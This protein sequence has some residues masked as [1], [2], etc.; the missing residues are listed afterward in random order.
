MKKFF[1]SIIVAM[2]ALFTT[3]CVHASTLEVNAKRTIEIKGVIRGN[4]IQAANV[5][6]RMSAKSDDDVFLIINSPGGAIYP[7]IQ[8]VSAMRM[9]QARGVTIKCLVPV[10][11]ASMAYQF[12]LYCDER[13]ALRNSLLLWHPAH[14]QIAGNADQLLYASKRLR[15]IEKPLVRDLIQIMGISKSFYSFHRR[16]ETLWTAQELNE[17]VPGFLTIID[18]VTGVKGIF[19]L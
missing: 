16:N 13:Y 3:S 15:A 18:N 2:A 6:E 17:R 12:Y 14:T 4:I 8:F 19:D 10:I 7:G 9:A 5:L 11:S 1:M